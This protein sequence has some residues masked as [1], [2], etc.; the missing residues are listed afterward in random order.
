MP[1]LRSTDTTSP[2]SCCRLDLG[3]VVRRIVLELLEEDAVL[4]DLAHGL[5]VGRAAHTDADRHR[6]AV[7]GDADD[8]HVVAEILAAELGADA[9]LARELQ[10][11]L[12]HLAVAD[13]HALVVAFA[14]QVVEVAR[15]G[16]LHRL[17]VHLGRGAADHDGEVVGRAGR[18]AQRADLGVEELQQ[19]CLVQHRRRLLVQVG[20]VGRA[21]ALGDEQ[22]FVG[23][24]VGGVDVDLRRQV[25]A[26]LHF[27]E[28]RERRDLRIAQVGLGVG[29]VDAAWRSPPRRRRRSTPPGPSCPSRSPCRCP[30]TSAARRR[31]RCWRSSAARAP[32]TCRWPRPRRRRGWRAAAPDGP[33][34]AD[35][36]CRGRPPPSAG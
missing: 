21:A 28:H 11:L 13:G 1:L 10:H 16:E 30:G 2:E 15:R 9:H 26:G 31:P 32:R 12:F 22:E 7:A 18:G 27:L 29:L 24:A 4:G 36:R 23:I 5:A 34:A 14:R 8:A 35:A 6:G 25:G 19:C 3:Q 33:A 17:E 20:L